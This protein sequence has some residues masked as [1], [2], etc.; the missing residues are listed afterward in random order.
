MTFAYADPPYPG[1]AKQHYAKDPS[2]IEAAEVDHAELIEQLKTF[3][4]WALST[5][6][7]S[8]RDIL[9][10]CPKE[11]RVGAW[12]KTFA[13]FKPHVRVAYS[14]EPVIFY[15]A[16]PKISR[17]EL[18]IHDWVSAMPPIF[19]RRNLDNT[20]GQKPIEFCMWLFALIGL[21]RG[22]KLVDLF[23]GSGAVTMFWENYLAQM[24]FD[25]TSPVTDAN[26]A[27]ETLM[28]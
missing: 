20:K 13:S 9:P 25:H 28:V 2:K 12:V 5:S 7:S 26:E 15:G 23:P 17:G 4:A 11:S 14:W 21:Q 3:D 6:S 16:R 24:T 22:D 1:C 18:T 10:L 27:Q 19:T 8:L